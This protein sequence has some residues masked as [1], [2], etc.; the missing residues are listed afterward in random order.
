MRARCTH[1]VQKHAC[2]VVHK[3]PR[4]SKKNA[5]CRQEND[6][7]MHAATQGEQVRALSHARTV[8]L[9]HVQLNARLFAGAESTF[10]EAVTATYARRTHTAD[11]TLPPPSTPTPTGATATS[12]GAPDPQTAALRLLAAPLA[13]ALPGTKAAPT[14][15]PP[16][17]ATG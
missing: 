13:G 5:S 2:L 1:A 9:P 15:Q 7:C 11:N 3:T 17:I 14:P 8:A 6:A 10:R 16:A 4:T 12:T